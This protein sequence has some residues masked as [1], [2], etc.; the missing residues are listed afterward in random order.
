MLSPDRI[1]D[2]ALLEDLAMTAWPAPRRMVHRGWAVYFADGHTGRA[3]SANALVPMAA[4]DD[5]GI[6]AVEQ[7][8]RRQSLPPMFRLTPLSPPGLLGRLLLRGYTVASESHVLWRELAGDGFEHAFDR[9][10]HVLSGF[11]PAWLDAYRTMVPVPDQEMPALTSILS[12]ITAD[13]RFAL[14]MQDGVPVAACMAVIDRG[15]AGFFKVAGRP[16]QRGRGYGRR[17]MSDMM[18]RAAADGATG[19]YLQVGTGNAPALALY[20]RLGFQGL[21]DYAYARK[22]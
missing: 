21:Y 10:V 19:A 16:D 18:V 12:A 8:Y 17:L 11:H 7:A 4:M 6:L 9:D 22:G 2:I 20:R 1:D 15:W 3:N 13:A 5:D 14:L